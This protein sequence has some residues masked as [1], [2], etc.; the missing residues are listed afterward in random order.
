M[1]YTEEEWIAKVD[2]LKAQ[3]EKY[4]S[5]YYKYGFTLKRIVDDGNM[6]PRWTGEMALNYWNIAKEAL[7]GDEE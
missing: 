7:K 2:A 1:S 5:K 3:M 6:S 4:K